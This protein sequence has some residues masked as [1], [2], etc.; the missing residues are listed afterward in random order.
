MI[1]IVERL[2]LTSKSCLR[3]GSLKLKRGAS[4]CALKFGILMDNPA[5]KKE[6]VNNNLH[7]Y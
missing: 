2:F 1:K 3:A 4:S 7:I 6:S 5:T